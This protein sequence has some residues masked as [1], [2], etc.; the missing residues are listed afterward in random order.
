MNNTVYLSEILKKDLSTL[1]VIILNININKNGKDFYVEGSFRSSKYA[2]VVFDKEKYFNEVA[3]ALTRKYKIPFS[4]DKKGF[5]CNIKNDYDWDFETFIRHLQ[6]TISARLISIANDANYDLDKEVALAMIGLR[7]SPDFQRKLVA[8][9]VKSSNKV[10]LDAFFRLIVSTNDIVKYLNWNFRELQKDY[11]SGKKR[12][13]QLRLNLRWVYDHI[14][15]DLKEINPYKYNIISSN[16]S[17]IG[18]LPKTDK[19]YE[20]FISRLTMYREQI[21]GKELSD[22]DIKQ[23]RNELFSEENKEP[24]RKA[25]VKLYVKNATVDKCSACGKL[26]DIKDRSFIVPKDNRYYFEY[27]HVISFA[28]DKGHLDV[29]DNLVKLCP[30]CHRAMTPHRAEA[31]YQKSLILNILNDRNDTLAFAKE[32]L[33]VDDINSAADK[34]QQMLA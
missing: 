16:K 21:A 14:L 4:S 11:I 27:H 19:T 5:R 32:Y 15:D 2:T 13:T 7:G 25:Q 3:K 12:N 20:T 31:D 1:L 8:T 17:L 34:I 28:N 29:T 18:S 23:L 26:Y 33:Q 22:T 24:T 9:D 6:A 10:Y 30:T